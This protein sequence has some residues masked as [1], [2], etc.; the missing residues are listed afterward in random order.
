MHHVM[1][2]MSAV[3]GLGIGETTGQVGVAML[4]KAMDAE[5][6]QMAQ[7]LEALPE[8]PPSLEPH[9]GRSVNALA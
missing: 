2:V 9:K 6:S 5:T 1:D 7:L 3:S 8:P 4:R